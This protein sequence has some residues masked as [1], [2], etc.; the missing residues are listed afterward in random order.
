MSHKFKT[1]NIKGKSYVQVNERIL[2]FRSEY[3]EWSIHTEII[4]ISDDEVLCIA[5]I[6]D[7]NNEVRFSGHAHEEKQASYINKTSYVE[8]CETSAVGRA[9]GIMGIGIETSIATAE[10]V[11]Q[12][13]NTQS[14]AKPK[15]TP[16]R[17]QWA[18][19]IEKLKSGEATMEKVRE[20]YFLTDRYAQELQM[21]VE[22]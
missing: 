22:L 7:E 20:H 18:K 3:P 21:E 13:I 1:T 10:E 12:A 14:N 17:P 11:N 2:F 9:L 4:S 15:L 16:D 6:L 8:N 19:V 5:R